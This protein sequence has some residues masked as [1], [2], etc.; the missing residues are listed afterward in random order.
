MTS[1][2]PMTTPNLP[3]N[4]GLAGQQLNIAA[5]AGTS[6]RVMAGPGTGKTFAMMRRIARLLQS[7]V[8]PDSI[9]AV[10]FTRTA[11]RDLL[12]QLNSLGSNGAKDVASSTL[13]SLSFSML[14]KNSVFQTTNRVARP[15]LQFE[16]GCLVS[17]L[18][19]Q[20]GGRVKT[21]GFLAAFETAWATLQHQQPGWPHN[22]DEQNFHRD[23]MDWLVF[24]E[25][26][27][28]GELVPLA[29]DFIRR[30]PASPDASAFDHVLVDEYQ[31]LNRAD[32]ELIESLA[33]QGS[34]TVIGDEDQSIYT[35]LRHAR[36][37][38]IVDFHQSHANTH[39]EALFECKRCPHRVIEMANSLILHNHPQ[40][41]STIQPAP[42][43]TSGI[44]YI[45]QHN[46]LQ[47]EVSATTAFIDHYLKQNP[48]AKRGEV[49]VLATRRLIGN[50]I[51][52]ELVG[53]Q[54][55]AQSFF[56]ED[57][58]AKEAAQQGFCL[59]KLLVHSNDPTALRVWLGL[60][61]SEHRSSTYFRVW[62]AA[63]QAN[64]SVKD[65]LTEVV[66]GSRSPVPYSTGLM[67]RFKDL[68]TRLGLL[69]G[70]SGTTL[71]DQLWPVGD[72]DCADVR[73]FALTLAGNSPQIADLL[74]ELT[75]VITQPELPGVDGDI[76]R[77]MS[78]QKSKGLTARCVIVVGCME[79]ALP[80]LRTNYS[81]SE[82]QQAYEEQRRLFYVAL[83]RTTETLVVS[84]AATGPY[85]D[86]VTMGIAPRAIVKG[87]SNIHSSPFLSEL[88]SSAPQMVSGN[89]WRSALGF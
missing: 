67:N 44:V 88:G 29:L 18:A 55:S 72:P 37:E 48:D 63:R 23:L 81:Q 38:G 68:S 27:L 59:L 5:Y 45:I 8:R 9:L 61:S 51:R 75:E 31:D 17:D 39:D 15:L 13:H 78:L 1:I 46:S 11:A 35:L 84:S 60:S 34:L 64:M 62:S 47:D 14:S 30:N 20:H 82:R 43:N 53:L 70:L 89:A 65:F 54:H 19:A 32:Q 12:G 66:N 4:A 50:R 25:S 76:I 56:T 57:C 87:I 3:W 79:G 36:P 74:D 52:D 28:I 26:M 71:V 24:H 80:F 40:R 83:T 77:I 22:Q 86:V 85:V 2:G 6:L 16:R 58:L 33:R 69:S 41:P 42:Q 49:L 10:T 7:G 21:N 73:G